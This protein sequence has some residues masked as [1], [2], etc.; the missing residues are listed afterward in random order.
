MFFANKKSAYNFVSVK[1]I[2]F[3]DYFSLNLLTI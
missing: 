1:I 3:E 2:I